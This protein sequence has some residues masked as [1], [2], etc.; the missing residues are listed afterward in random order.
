[1]VIL[2][3]GFGDMVFNTFLNNISVILWRLV[4]LV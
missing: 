1:M 2:H 4:L 3:R